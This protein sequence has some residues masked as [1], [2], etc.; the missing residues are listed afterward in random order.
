MPHLCKYLE[1]CMQ[2]PD[3]DSM[4]ISL[5][6]CS[7]PSVMPSSSHDQSG[8]T[9][10]ASTSTSGF[11]AIS[12]SSHIIIDARAC[13]AVPRPTA[14]LRVQLPEQVPGTGQDVYGSPR[15]P[16]IGP[17]PSPHVDPPQLD[18]AHVQAAE[19]PRIVAID[20]QLWHRQPWTTDKSCVN[21]QSYGQH[22]CSSMADWLTP[23]VPASMTS[24]M[25]SSVA[26]QH[27]QAA[28]R[29]PSHCSLRP[30]VPDAA[31]SELF[32]EHPSINTGGRV[33]ASPSESL[34]WPLSKPEHAPL[35]PSPFRDI[36]ND[37]TRRCPSLQP[38]STMPCKQAKASVNTSSWLRPKA[39]P[40][41]GKSTGSIQQGRDIDNAENVDGQDGESSDAATCVAKRQCLGRSTIQASVSP[42]LVGKPV[43]ASKPSIPT[44]MATRQNAVR[45]TRAGPS[46]GRQACADQP[47]RPAHMPKW[48]ASTKSDSK[49]VTP[50]PIAPGRGFTRTRSAAAQS[51]ADSLKRR[52]SLNSLRSSSI[53]HA[54]KK[55]G[56][57]HSSG[58]TGSASL[59]EVAAG[60]RMTAQRAADSAAPGLTPRAGHGKPGRSA[61]P[62]PVCEKGFCIPHSMAPGTSAG[63]SCAMSSSNVPSEGSSSQVQATFPYAS[64]EPGLVKRIG[65]LQDPILSFSPEQS[66]PD[67]VYSDEASSSDVRSQPSAKSRWQGLR[68]SNSPL[69]EPSLRHADRLTSDDILHTLQQ[70]GGGLKGSASLRGSGSTT[71]DIVWS[72]A[73]S[74]C[75]NPT[76]APTLGV[77]S[78]LA[79]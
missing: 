66:S 43:P 32:H 57:S 52:A 4:G 46:R 69:Y 18:T 36:T 48:V 78:H 60:N 9:Q 53:Q 67:V 47:H 41:S 27:S 29:S 54:A 44:Q 71:T 11:T 24:S 31:G 62:C 58:S 77:R 40:Q 49:A 28:A 2:V 19:L 12:A 50:E 79:A 37:Q 64:P 38:S 59:I 45:S 3:D 30:Q 76:F 35:G 13:P 74:A 70:T 14:T 16:W 17:L 10:P 75:S 22:A 21:G 73:F 42:A 25:P 7:S 56:Q 68:M 55:R 5:T 65:E 15:Q 6:R 20:S 39:R 26:S 63:S 1:W 51:L 34:C 33:Q 61:R 23:A 8:L 72:A